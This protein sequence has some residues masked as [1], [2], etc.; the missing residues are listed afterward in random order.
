MRR[1]TLILL[2]LAALWAHAAL[3]AD[4]GDASSLW[5]QAIAWML[6]HQRQFH[7]DL[8]SHLRELATGASVATAWALVAVSF[9]YGIFH[10]AGPGH[11][12]A[13]IATYL[14]THESRLRRGVGLAMASAMLQGGVAVV[15]VCG[16]IGL[17]DWL[18]G[19]TRSTIAWSERLSF[20]LL[21]VMGAL[22]AGRGLR[23]AV[24]TLRPAA[25][26]EAL[27]H[28]HE[29]GETCGCSHGPSHH[30][31]ET[32]AGMRA[33]IGI[34]LSVGL[35]PCSGAVLVLVLAN[36]LG[37]IWAGIVAV[38]A[39]SL[40]TAITVA[41]LAIVTVKARHWTVAV[42]GGADGAMKWSGT[43]AALVGGG[44]I[45]LV[46]LSLLTASFGPGHPLWK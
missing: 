18:P 6:H 27:H 38:V 40:G 23:R 2:G 26:T 24:V 25:P 34:L 4:A 12:K 45:F 8:A 37:L 30:Q 17:A 32:V 5:D 46:G 9:L 36:V 35:R 13:V 43:I 42:F 16:M 1:P 7:R 15:L 3:A 20:A 29:H 14:L 21:M 33:T 44:A 22:F 10:A 31:I 28:H 41:S 39:M 11:G 19:E